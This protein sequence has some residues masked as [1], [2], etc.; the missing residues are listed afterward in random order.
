METAA[1][2]EKEPGSKKKVRFD[3]SHEMDESD[4]K[5]GGNK[6]ASKLISKWTLKLGSSTM[7]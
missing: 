3:L 5:G 6:D 7:N 1:A 2:T 4:A